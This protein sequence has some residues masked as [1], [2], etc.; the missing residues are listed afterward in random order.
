MLQTDSLPF[1]HHLTSVYI[2]PEY[3]SIQVSE[4]TIVKVQLPESCAE[5]RIEICNLPNILCGDTLT[6]FSSKIEKTFCS[7]YY[8][9]NDSAQCLEMLQNCHKPALG[10]EKKEL[11]KELSNNLAKKITVESNLHLVTPY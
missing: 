1:V 10:L 4:I 3:Y 7:F 11:H 5:N 2:L 9:S 6:K 8:Q